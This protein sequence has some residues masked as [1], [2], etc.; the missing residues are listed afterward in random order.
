MLTDFRTPMSVKRNGKGVVIG[1]L[2]H[3]YTNIFFVEG[4]NSSMRLFFVASVMCAV[5]AGHE[6]I[7]MYFIAVIISKIELY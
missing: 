3:T 4:C 6:R 5:R 7:L 2:K 1:M